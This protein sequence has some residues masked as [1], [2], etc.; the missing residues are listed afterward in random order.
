MPTGLMSATWPPR[1]YRSAETAVNATRTAAAV[2]SMNPGG[3]AADRLSWPGYGRGW[4]GVRTLLSFRVLVFDMARTSGVGQA[5]YLR[6]FA[7][8]TATRPYDIYRNPGVASR[9]TPTY[10]TAFP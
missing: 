9:L 3:P 8:R 7:L 6:K 5:S 10:I 1:V 4:M 2:G